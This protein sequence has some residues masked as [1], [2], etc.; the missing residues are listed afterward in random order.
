MTTKYASMFVKVEGT[1][2]AIEAMRKL[3]PA[4]RIKHMR[5]ALLAAGGVIKKEIEATA[6]RDSGLL[7]KSI[8]VKAIIPQASKNP[9]YHD[10]PA[11]V[12]IGPGRGLTGV[13]RRLK[14][15]KLGVLSVRTFKSVKKILDADNKA[16]RA[17][18]LV[19][20]VS[21]RSIL[22]QRLMTLETKR[23]S[24]YAHFAEKGRLGRG[25]SHFM[26]LAAENKAAAA[27]AKFAAKI[28]QGILAE[29][30]RLQSKP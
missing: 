12:F 1:L 7:M 8:R 26:N 30:K 17:A 11:S 5:I 14:S 9:D 21:G 3:E 22:K 29:A 4:V 2:Q 19:R 28:G 20:E 15:G 25:G 16:G 23:A 6:P 10:R 27:N 24:R 18:S 13:R